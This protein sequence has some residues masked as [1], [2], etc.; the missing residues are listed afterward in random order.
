MGLRCA[1]MYISCSLGSAS[2]R[3]TLPID[4]KKLRNLVSIEQDAKEE[5]GKPK[6]GTGSEHILAQRPHDSVGA[7][8]VSENVDSA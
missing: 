2:D 6:G 3:M 1:R 5:A 8:S 7:G 4:M